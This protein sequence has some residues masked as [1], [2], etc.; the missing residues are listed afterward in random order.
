SKRF[1]RFG[2]HNP[3]KIAKYPV[4]HQFCRFFAL[5]Q[6]DGPKHSVYKAHV[7]QYNCQSAVLK[8]TANDTLTTNRRGLANVLAQPF[9]SCK[10]A[11]PMMLRFEA[12]AASIIDKPYAVAT[13]HSLQ[14]A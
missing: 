14:S 12:R 6:I 3:E 11:R 13:A 9:C 2:L 4:N 5:I 7:L 10:T 8:S 1:E